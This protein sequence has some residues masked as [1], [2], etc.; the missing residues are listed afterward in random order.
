M[1]EDEDGVPDVSQMIG[2]TAG[3]LKMATRSDSDSPCEMGPEG[4]MLG[5]ESGLCCFYWA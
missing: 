1:G 2:K 3:S 4:R 5:R